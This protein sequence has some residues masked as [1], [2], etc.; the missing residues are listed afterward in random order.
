MSGGYDIDENR[1]KNRGTRQIILPGID[2][3]DLVN[4][5]IREKRFGYGETSYLLLFG[6]LPGGGAA[7]RLRDTSGPAERI[8][9]HFYERYDH[10]QSLSEHH[11][12]DG[13]EHPLHV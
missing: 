11:E 13:A 8:A 12:P 10:G 2:V 1:K 7:K 3:E 4:A 5:S 6:E 9:S